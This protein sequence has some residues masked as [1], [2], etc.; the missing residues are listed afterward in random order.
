V[1]V[2]RRFPDLAIAQPRQWS[3]KR[4][5]IF[6]NGYGQPY[7]RAAHIAEYFEKAH[8]KTGVR[9]SRQP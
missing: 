1:N 4:G 7:M 5:E 9:R 3:F 8:A 2:Q 6:L